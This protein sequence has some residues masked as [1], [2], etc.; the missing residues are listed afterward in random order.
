MR[1][2]SSLFIF[3]LSSAMM[4][5]P[6]LI[7]SYSSSQNRCSPLISFAARVQRVDMG[8]EKTG[9]DSSFHADVFVF[10]IHKLF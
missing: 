9:D 1:V 5:I 10:S 8:E 3:E 2:S 4:S 7:L 6:Y